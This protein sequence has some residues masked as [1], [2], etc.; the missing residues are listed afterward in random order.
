MAIIRWIP[1]CLIHSRLVRYVCLAVGAVV[2]MGLPCPGFA[3]EGRISAALTRGGEPQP[4]RYTVGTNFFR[5]ERPETNWPY[6]CDL[7]NL[8][9][10]EVTLLFPHNHSFM[11]LRNGDAD[12]RPLQPAG[13]A[14]MPMMPVQQ[15]EL[16]ATGEK[17]NL[18]GYA[19][20]RYEL[21]QPGQLMEI[22]ATD[23]LLPFQPYLENAPHRPGPQMLEEQWGDLLKAKKLF[24]LLAILK[25]ENG[26]ERLRFAVTSVSPEKIEDQ[27]GAL[28]QPPPGYHE[29]QPLPF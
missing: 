19:C 20:A 24:P 29:I 5:V 9:S 11:R 1:F 6:A 8:R 12:V 21:K 2:L 14:T 25:L 17:T 28:F 15:A 7:V 18:L 4:L 16:K 23:Q 27:D 26:A 10:G 3:F 13:P 22:W